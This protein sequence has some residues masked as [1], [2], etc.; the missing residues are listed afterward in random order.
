MKN[1]FG[2]MALG[3]VLALDM[4]AAPADLILG[5]N[6]QDLTSYARD[7]FHAFVSKADFSKTATCDNPARGFRLDDQDAL[8]IIEQQ[9]KLLAHELEAAEKTGVALCLSTDEVKFPAAVWDVLRKAAPDP[10]HPERVDLTSDLFWEFY[11]VKYREVLARMPACAKYVMVRTGE[12]YPT[13]IKGFNGQT[14][15]IG[16]DRSSPDYARDMAR[17]INETRRLVVDEFGRM[18]VWRTWDLGNEGFHANTNVYDRVM[19][20][21]TNRTGLVMAIKFVQTDYWSYNDFNP[22]IARDPANKLI[23][24]QSCREYEG[25][26]VYPNYVGELHGAALRRLAADPRVIGTWLWGDHAGGSGGPY[27]ETDVWQRMNLET[28]LELIHHPER[29]PR[30]VLLAWCRRRFGEVA[31]PGVTKA[32]LKTHECVEKMLYVG[33]FAKNHRG[34]KPHLNITRDDSIGGGKFREME[35]I[36]AEVKENLGPVFREKEE[37]L[38]LAGNLRNAFEAQKEAIVS[39]KGEETYKLSLTGF[40]YLERLCDVFRLYIQG[41]FSYLRWK[42]TLS[43][44]DRVRAERTLQQWKR[45]WEAYQRDIPNLPGRP[46]PYQS[47]T[48][49]KT[50]EGGMEEICLAAIKDLSH[51]PDPVAKLRA[52]PTDD[53]E[54]VLRSAGR[55]PLPQNPINVL[56]LGDSLSDRSRGAN[57][58]DMLATAFDRSVRGHATVYNYA[59]GGDDITR[60]LSRLQGEKSVFA[61]DRYYGLA[62][63]HYDWAIV[64]LGH[65]DTKAPSTTNY[66]KPIV[67]PAEQETAYLKVMAKL[68]ELGVTRIIL[69]SSAS[70]D[71]KTC[72]ENAK[73]YGDKPH[74]RFGM[75]EH[76]EAFN[77]V[78]K[79]LAA[80]PDV[81]YVDLYTPMKACADKSALF[82]PGDGVHLSEAGFA[83]VG[84][85]LLN[86]FKS[87]GK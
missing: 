32:L 73:K 30:R 18:L 70:S 40:I 7:G 13:A 2:I 79:K 15:C 27:C 24:F 61:P 38:R 31:A 62:D 57:H 87:S 23:E 20:G 17:L 42:E 3:A 69:I 63:R 58:I 81:E 56:V 43:E 41:Y 86:H 1:K 68:R 49:F 74:N 52:R 21:V 80:K 4:G 25:K 12:N 60:V 33:E 16:G 10:Q 26:G 66:R 8:K 64:F 14:V 83:F 67:P 11:R 46:T 82:V 84:Q 75:H 47:R 34:W 44:G 39:A 65:N 48:N 72:A 9:R 50:P 77:R 55:L 51:G 37:A 19:S 6:E 76:Q 53:V 71:E 35:H 78:L 29:D 5:C 28:S 45:T 54:G 59:I 85:V 36:Y 22:C